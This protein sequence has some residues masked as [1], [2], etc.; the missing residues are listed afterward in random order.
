MLIPRIKSK[1]NSIITTVFAILT[2]EFVQRNL[3][4]EHFAKTKFLENEA[5]Y[6]STHVY[7]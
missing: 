5:L 6:G 3:H 2:T 4:K 7:S 1:F